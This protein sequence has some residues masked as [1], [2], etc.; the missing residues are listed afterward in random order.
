MQAS[1]S[2]RSGLVSGEQI[3]NIAIRG[4]DFMALVGLLPGV[5]DTS[6]GGRE[7][8]DPL[9]GSGSVVINGNSGGMKN[10]TLDGIMSMDTGNNT[11]QVF[12]SNMDSVA[13]VKVLTSNFQAEYGRNASNISVIT[14]GGSRDFHGGAYHYYRHE[15]LNANN[16]FNNRSGVQR[17]VYRYRIWGYTVGGPVYIPGKFNRE[18]D[19][20]FFFFSQEN[21]G[22][23][24]DWGTYLSWMPTALEKTGRFLELARRKRQCRHHQGPDHRAGSSP[25]TSSRRTA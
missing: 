4:R 11:G 13:E 17:P 5:I 19:K 16:F 1:S 3:N 21:T 8:A 23:K 18:R 9:T 25:G 24:S 12:Q 7:V 6:S 15:T 22:T 2:E 10:V 14:K 20:L